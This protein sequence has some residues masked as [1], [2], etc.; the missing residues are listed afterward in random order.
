MADFF[1]HVDVSSLGTSYAI[2]PTCKFGG[3][4]PADTHSQ[5]LI[6]FS[7]AEVIM[8]SFDGQNDHGRLDVSGPTIGH[9]WLN[10][11]RSQLWLRRTATGGGAQYVQVY[12]WK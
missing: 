9:S 10:H 6:N 11:D 7:A 3:V 12:A 2:A 4:V 1:A 8:V 5:E